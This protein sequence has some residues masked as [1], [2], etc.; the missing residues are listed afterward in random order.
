MKG[1]SQVL[2]ST[3]ILAVAVSVAAVYGNWAPGFAGDITGETADQ[4]NRDIRCG[5]AAL[6]IA[7]AEYDLSGNFTEVELRNSGTINLNQGVE[8]VVFNNQSQIIGQDVIQSI[9]A[10]ETGQ[11]RIDSDEVPDRMAASSRD[12]PGEV[13]VSTDMIRVT[14]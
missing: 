2:T 9:Q 3:I 10:A 8:V 5:N 11:T 1:V 12:C 13:A 6:S 14:E 7:T 4:T